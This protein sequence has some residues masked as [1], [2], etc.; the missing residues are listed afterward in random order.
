MPS[1]STLAPPAVA[2]PIARA[3]TAP[4]GTAT[5]SQRARA[6]CR[7]WFP[8]LVRAHCGACSTAGLSAI[9]ATLARWGLAGHLPG[10]AVPVTLPEEQP[11][12]VRPELPPA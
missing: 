2:A 5:T 8:L 12:S 9:A 7:M 4:A 11:T 3:A 1:V 10:R 6:R